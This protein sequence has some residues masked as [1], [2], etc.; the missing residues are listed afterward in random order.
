LIAGDGGRIDRRSLWLQI[1]TVGGAT[2]LLLAPSVPGWHGSPE[3]HSLYVVT[4]PIAAILLASY[5]GLTV[6]N[7]RVHQHD[8]RT[9]AAEGAWPLRVALG[10]LAI[11]TVA[12]ALV[13]ESLVS[14]LKEFGHAVGLDEFFIAAVIVA[15]V[16]NAAEH[17]GAIVISSRGNLKLATE[18]AITS[19]MQVLL[20]VAPAV[21]LLS[22]VVGP[23][24]PL[25]FRPVEIATL[26]ISA[27][28]AGIVVANGRTTRREG[29]ALVALY[30]AMAA[31]YLVSGDRGV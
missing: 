12:T 21:A 5:V 8:E 7:L 30:L 25:A 11:A 14:S 3:R 13:S 17:G 1:A 24:L 10:V 27:G 15:I 23:D 19:S 26:A 29:Y 9:A 16:G 20:F 6:Y 4:V 2:L 18:I 28:A 31:A 22:F